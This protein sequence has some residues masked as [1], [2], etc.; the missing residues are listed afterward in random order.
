MSWGITTGSLRRSREQPWS[1]L[2]RLH[3]HVVYRRTFAM[4]A[5]RHPQEGLLVHLRDGRPFVC[6]V[7]KS[8]FSGRLTC[9][10]EE[11]RH[12]SFCRVTRR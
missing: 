7:G 12:C 10:P 6:R 8:G 3:D 5:I 4:E 9:P 2:K 11:R 1:L